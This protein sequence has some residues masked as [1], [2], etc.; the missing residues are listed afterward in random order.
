M[1][2]TISQIKAEGG[3]R[4][5]KKRVRRIVLLYALSI[6]WIPLVYYLANSP[7][8]WVVS[9]PLII[10]TF[11]VVWTWNQSRNLFYHKVKANPEL[12]Q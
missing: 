6:A 5:L 12:L 4:F 8:W 7:R 9:A 10:V 2:Y 3:R 1:E 11:N